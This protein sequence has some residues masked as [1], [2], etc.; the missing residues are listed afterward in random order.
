MA[1]AKAEES[2]A[3]LETMKNAEITELRQVITL[4]NLK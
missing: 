4:M 1:L 3:R 2:K